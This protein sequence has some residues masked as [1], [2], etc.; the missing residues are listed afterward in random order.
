MAAPKWVS[1]ADEIRAQI[2]SG[3]L[4]P[5]DKLPSTSQLCQIY[6]VSTIVIRNAMITLKAEGFVEGVPGVG[7][8]VT[9]NP[10]IGRKP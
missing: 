4:K 6:E 7:V 9:K 10:P 2:T 5:G 1:L 3:K 8:Y